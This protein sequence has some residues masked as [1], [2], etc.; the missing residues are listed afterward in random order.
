MSGSWPNVA[1]NLNFGTLQ[2]RPLH[3]VPMYINSSG[4]DSWSA[5]SMAN[6][7]V[8]GVATLLDSQG[9]TNSLIWR[10]IRASAIELAPQLQGSTL[11]LRPCG[12]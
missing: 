12:C 11:R 2:V 9:L 3:A 7:F 1:E 10:R 4:Y 6:P 8:A 5:T